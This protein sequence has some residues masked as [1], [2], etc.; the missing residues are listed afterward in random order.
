[1]KKIWIFMAATVLLLLSG[2]R[3]SEDTM[4]EAVDN[5]TTEE[6]SAQA[7]EQTEEQVI[8][9]FLSQEER[10]QVQE[11]LSENYQ[12][13]LQDIKTYGTMDEYEMNGGRVLTVPTHETWQRYPSKWKWTVCICDEGKIYIEHKE[14]DESKLYTNT[15]IKLMPD[16]VWYL[17]DEEVRSH[18]IFDSFVENEI[19]AYDSAV[20]RDMYMVNYCEE[21]HYGKNDVFD[22]SWNIFGVHF[23]AEDL[24]GDEEDELMVFLQRGTS[25]GDLFVFD[26]IDGKLYAWQ[27]WE[28]FYDDRLSDMTCYDD[29]MICMTGA[30]GIIYGH[31]N[32]DGM[33]EAMWWRERCEHV[34]SEN[35]DEM[36]KYG[37]VTLYKGG[38]D[39]EH[40]VKALSYEGI[41]LSDVIYATKEDTS[42]WTPENSLI[43]KE[44]DAIVEEWHHSGE[45]RIILPIQS[46]KEAGLIMLNDLLRMGTVPEGTEDTTRL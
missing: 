39:V 26:E 20:N 31:Y 8:A 2:C 46:E 16:M 36:Y 43:K 32:S 44:C 13:L 41:W 17:V 1:M 25:G 19:S 12:T 21:Y 27:K 3:E 38:I 24:D 37:T 9:E 4:V 33:L 5:A 11:L 22:E 42:K 23:M 30:L 7:F 15:N 14:S 18:A 10:E 28:G 45:G 6:S 34:D 29:G 40:N 35:E